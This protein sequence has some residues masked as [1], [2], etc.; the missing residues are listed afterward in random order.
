MSVASMSQLMKHVEGRLHYRCGHC[1][2]KDEGELASGRLPLGVLH[3]Y[4]LVGASG[5]TLT[6]LH[7]KP[8]RLIVDAP[9]ARWAWGRKLPDSNR[10]PFDPLGAGPQRARDSR[11]EHWRYSS[12]VSDAIWS[13]GASY[14]GVSSAVRDT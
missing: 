14:R 4:A 7:A 13:H 6:P 5:A 1:L 12:A 9:P 8:V 11:G 3:L 10:P 2:K